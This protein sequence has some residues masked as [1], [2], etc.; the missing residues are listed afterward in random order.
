MQSKAQLNLQ[1]S[2]D[3]AF[4]NEPNIISLIWKKRNDADFYKIISQNFN[5]LNISSLQ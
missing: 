3:G 4:K 5:N 1:T 2:H